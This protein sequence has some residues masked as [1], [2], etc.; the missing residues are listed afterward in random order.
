MLPHDADRVDSNSLP[1][2]GYH[3]NDLHPSYADSRRHFHIISFGKNLV[4]RSPCYTGFFYPLVNMASLVFFSTQKTPAKINKFQI[5]E[6]E[7]GSF[8]KVKAILVAGS[9]IIKIGI[10]FAIYYLFIKPE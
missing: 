9:A 4:G 10:V 7:H 3:R 2:F 6:A 5:T 1:G 8:W